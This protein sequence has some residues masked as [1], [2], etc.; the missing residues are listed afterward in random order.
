M[1]LS[2]ILNEI[3]QD[4]I[5]SYPMSAHIV[6][7][8]NSTLQL[9]GDAVIGPATTGAMAIAAV[10]KSPRE[11]QEEIFA[12]DFTPLRK[13]DSYK[14]TVLSLAG[15][16][17]FVGLFFAGTVAKFEGQAAEGFFDV[18][19]VLISGLFEVIKLVVTT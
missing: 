18:F 5:S 6:G 8:L 19:K 14:V 9:M 12:K 17:V 7:Y 15:M 3:D 1:K 11:T 10:Y 2:D 4:P 13:K 16:A